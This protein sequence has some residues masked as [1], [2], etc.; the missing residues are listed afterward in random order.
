MGK[1]FI[2]RAETGLSR[3]AARLALWFG[4]AALSSLC[5]ADA[6]AQ[7][8]APAQPAG[9]AAP[10]EAPAVIEEVVV[11]SRHRQENSQKVPAALSI[12]GGQLL[13]RTNTT[14]ISQVSQ[15][16]PSIQFTYFNARNANIN[17]RGLGNNVGL[18]NDGL[19]PGV[20]FYVDQIY[21]SRPATATLDLIDVDRVEVLRG[22]QGTLFGKNTTAGA[23]NVSTAEPSF[24]PQVLAEITGGNYGYGQGKLAVTGPLINGLLAGRLTI[25]TTTRE[26]FETNVF[27][28]RKVN[29]YRDSTFRGQLLFT[30]TS[31]LKF[32]LIGDYERQFNHCCVNTLSGIVSPPNGK[33]FTTLAQSFG[34]TPVVDPFNRTVDVN[35]PFR[36]LQETGGISLEADWS[37]PRLT[38]TSITA[39]RF[40]NW[41]PQN[42]S[43]STPLPVVNLAQNGDYENQY[44]Q[45]FRIASA[46]VNLVD[47]VA[48]LYVYRET[49]H[50]VGVT[51]YGA[52]ASAF[53]GGATLPSVVLNNLTNRVDSSYTTDSYAAYGQATWHITRALNFTG[54]A[55]YTEDDKRGTFAQVSS[56]A[57][58]L[59]GS[60]AAL[61]AVRSA[62]GVTTS[63]GVKNT[64]A[65]F[66]GAA[67]LSYQATPD[68][69]TYVNYARGYK[70]GGLNLAQLPAG[71]NPVIK[72]ESID[73]VE[74]GAKTTL[75]DRSLILNLAVFWEKDENYQATILDPILLKLYLANVPEVRSQGI[76]ADL[77]ARPTDNL[78]IYG[79]ATYDD[80]VY[81]KY[82]GA[83]C[84][85]ELAAHASCDLSG[86][87]L[88]GAPRW[89]VSAGGE[90]DYPVNIGAREAEAYLGV[91]Y[92]YRSA[93][94]SA[95]TDSVY[96]E[97]A[98]L[99]LVNARI[100]LRSRAQYWD[101]YLWSKNITDAKYYNFIQ[102]GSGNTGA[103]YAGLG[104]PRTYGVTLRLKY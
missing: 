85:L 26:G 81:A 62:F 9:A 90:Y 20:G 97:L 69:L 31:D 25:G 38:L 60:L 32:R 83:P 80:A 99:N 39:W 74:A 77:Q 79:S 70:S 33:N 72:P 50:A 78:S 2:G 65:N 73:S 29:N 21:Y 28:G 5:A 71:A 95:A 82:P 8:A 58:P 104:D 89:A 87:R 75:F 84:G 22:P 19:D 17:V 57:A 76:E 46:G 51:Q 11:T 3:R 45:E 42:D 64:K 23:I 1:G 13:Q 44:T 56:G 100:G 63:F 68:V 52:D 55:R 41:W 10:Q 36:A 96:T 67:N 37:L 30:P 91:D 40:W 92:S 34:Y 102:P 49:I 94:N 24:K 35:A 6:S 43:D 12:V 47:Y 103:L 7:T 18:A 4:G 66:S 86:R 54:G 101:I 48:G 53:L 14:N 27:N 88:A 59:N 93:E 16:V 98:P 61:A 15:F